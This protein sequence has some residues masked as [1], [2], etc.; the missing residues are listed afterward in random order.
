MA[1]WLGVSKAEFKRMPH[2]ETRPRSLWWYSCQRVPD[3]MD[4]V[5]TADSLAVIDGYLKRAARGRALPEGFRADLLRWLQD[6]TR[7]HPIQPGARR[8]RYWTIPSY[9]LAHWIRPKTLC[10]R[11][12]EME[13]VA[14]KLFP[15]RVP[16]YRNTAPLTEETKKA[17]RTYYIEICQQARHIDEVVEDERSKPLSELKP[18]LVWYSDLHK[19]AIGTIAQEFGIPAYRVGQLCSAERQFLSENE[20]P[21][22]NQE[23]PPQ[24]EEEPF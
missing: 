11:F 14:K 12:R 3:G 13:K 16:T 1:N 24:A 19:A 4:D 9:E 21:H 18:G 17:V 10:K 15:E 6:L 5:P 8:K 22:D 7:E 2:A 23:P 20:A